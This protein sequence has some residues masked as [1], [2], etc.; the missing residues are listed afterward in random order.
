MTSKTLAEKTLFQVNTKKRV[1]TQFGRTSTHRVSS[2]F[3]NS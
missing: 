3:L 1:T 2:H